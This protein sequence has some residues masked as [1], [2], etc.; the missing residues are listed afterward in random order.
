MNKLILLLL[1]FSLPKGFC[2]ER[3]K[4]EFGSWTFGLNFQQSNLKMNH[5]EASSDGSF[6]APG[7]RSTYKRNSFLFSLEKEIMPH[8]PVS[9]SLYPM[10]GYSLLTQ[11]NDNKGS[12]RYEESLTG[13][14]FGGGV[15][16][17]LNFLSPSSKTQFFVSSASLQVR[18]RF[19]FRYQDTDTT[20]RSSE[21]ETVQSFNLLQSSIGF[22]FYN[23]KNLVSI[24]AITVFQYDDFDLEVDASRGDEK[25][26][27]SE[28]ALI[29]RDNTSFNIGFGYVF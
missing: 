2:E 19:F 12:F 24:F 29:E 28:F 23:T 9:I 4:F 8:W 5:Q 11:S 21:I 14:S 17:N 18:D 1:I 6:E 15:S 3:S 22:K 7:Y 20:V 13:T 25:F 16:L 10:V 27:L 26:E